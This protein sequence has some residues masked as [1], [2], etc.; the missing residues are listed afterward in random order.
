MKPDGTWFS[1]KLTE[2]DAPV[3]NLTTFAD[4]VVGTKKNKK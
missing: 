3:S 4:R 2:P 1:G